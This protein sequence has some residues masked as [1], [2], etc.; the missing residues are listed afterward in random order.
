M[1]KTTSYNSELLGLLAPPVPVSLGA[2][3]QLHS[4]VT[5][6]EE[7]LEIHAVIGPD[8][9]PVEMTPDQIPGPTGDRYRAVWESISRDETITL[10]N[11]NKVKNGRAVGC[12]GLSLS[13]GV[14]HADFQGIPYYALLAA[15]EMH[16]GN[17]LLEGAPPI[18]LRESF[19][20]GELGWGP[21]IAGGSVAV[22]ALHEGRRKL[23]T[24]IKGDEVLNGKQ[25]H[26]YAFAGG[27]KQ[28]ELHLGLV[29]LEL[30][31]HREYLEEGGDGAP[32]K[33]SR[34]VGVVS[35]G[36]PP[37]FRSFNHVLQRED[38]HPITLE[39]F[40]DCVMIPYATN[41]K[42]EVHPSKLEVR[43]WHIIDL[44]DPRIIETGNGIFSTGSS[45][46]INQDSNGNR[47]VDEL[48]ESR[49][50]VQPVG[51]VLADLLV[52]GSGY[53]EIVLKEA[54]LA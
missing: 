46:V 32:Y 42:P 53:R 34:T 12:T 17:V 54:K 50:L 48:I 27:L 2:L 23:I 30:G 26:I 33:L 9:M 40:I 24:Q 10:T 13:D 31:T 35:E 52:P 22:V 16:T 7:K 5:P 21:G 37:E 3:H 49:R 43:G 4:R 19:A 47:I 51:G 15:K 36:N 14:V 38:Q 6:I 18:S 1:L 20:A 28:S 41:R 8:G 44:D 29:Q 25:V 45:Y 39:E 11:G